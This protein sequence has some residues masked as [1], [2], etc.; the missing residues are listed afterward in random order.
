MVVAASDI[1]IRY[2][3]TTGSAGNSTAGTRAGSLGKYMSTT[4]VANPPN[5]YFDDVSSSEAS[6]GDTEYSCVFVYNSHAT[7][8]ALNVGVQVVSE[9]AGGGTTTAALDNIATSSAGSASA[10]AAQVA[11]E[12]TAPSGVG[13]FGTSLLSIGTLLA[14]QCKAVWL[15][16]TVAA[17]TAAIVG[18]GFTLR[19]TGDG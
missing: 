15:K 3:V 10:Q 9:V 6:A 2:S 17:S 18:D 5:A 13:T 19:V 8:S 12:N 7:D 14:G 16:R 11:D 4:D 1:K